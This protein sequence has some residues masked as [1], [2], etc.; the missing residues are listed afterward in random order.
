MKP[1]CMW[2]SNRDIECTSTDKAFPCATCPGPQSIN[3][4]EDTMESNEIGATSGETSITENQVDAQTPPAVGPA[5][6]QVPDGEV[7][8]NAEIEVTVAAGAPEAGMIPDNELKCAAPEPI[9]MA[10]AD[11]AEPPQIDD[12]DAGAADI[13]EEEDPPVSA[14]KLA[15][16]IE[17]APPNVTLPE[18]V[19]AAGTE[20]VIERAGVFTFKLPGRPWMT[21]KGRTL[22][23]AML[24]ARLI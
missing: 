22:Y 10:A 23:G 13:V 18:S 24:D 19:L 6:A 21:G 1:T 2:P 4:T 8:I 5:D 9:E 17:A 15:E 7:V 16:H 3:P 11:L 20:I 14:R 12:L